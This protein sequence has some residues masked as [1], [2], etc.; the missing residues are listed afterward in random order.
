MDH[1]EQ[2][3]TMLQSII[4][5]TEEEAA[6][7]MHDYFVAKTREVAGLGSQ[8]ADED[9]DLSVLDDELGAEG[10]EQE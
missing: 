7:T 5:G 2:L 9:L 3:K 4:N 8:A 6:V 1:K 10:T